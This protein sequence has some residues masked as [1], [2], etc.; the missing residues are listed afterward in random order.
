MRAKVCA[1]GMEREFPR[2]QPL[3][4]PHEV[5]LDGRPV[6]YV[7]AADV[8]TGVVWRCKTDADG[9]IV[10]DRAREEFVI[11]RVTGSIRVRPL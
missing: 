2:F 10:V 5:L 11:E 1:P 6:P 8:A 3:E 4:T 7:A 9:N